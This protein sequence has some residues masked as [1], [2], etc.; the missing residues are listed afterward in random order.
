MPVYYGLGVRVL[1]EN[2]SPRQTRVGA[3]VP[4][5]GEYLLDRAPLGIFLE[6]VPILDLIPATNFDISV[7]G[8]VRYYF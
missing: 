7:A 5:G 6:I 4:L 1:F 3:R 2:T 8:G